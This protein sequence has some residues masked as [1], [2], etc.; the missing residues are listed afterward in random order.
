MKLPRILLLAACIMAAI[1]LN[2]NTIKASDITDS[3]GIGS[4]SE[5]SVLAGSTVTNTGATVL[6]RSLGLYPG[7][8]VTGF[9]PGLVSAPG[10]FEVATAAAGQAQADLTG[11]YMD[12]A[13]RALTGTIPAD[14]AGQTLGSGVYAAS[15]RGPLSLGGTVVLDA[16]GN[17][18]AVFIFQTDSSLT[19]AS[20]SVVSLI[21][22]AQACRVHWVVGSSATLG[23]GSTFV[24][25][26]MAQESITV[27][28]GATVRGRVLARSG[29]VTL[30]SNVFTPASCQPP[31][32][33]PPSTEGPP[34]TVGTPPVSVPST[35]KPPSGPPPGRLPD[36]GSDLRPVLWLATFLVAAGLTVRRRIRV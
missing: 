34:T 6:P 10:V 21:G 25:T 17:T 5:Y 28:T 15:D 8:S 35:P 18:D 27:T 32:D 36:T 13:G 30:D 26:I 33:T 29:A 14:L 3:P 2:V 22:G 1:G 24:G 19:T 16:G 9:P 31:Q 23:T 11:G 12:A 4:A 7:T 20:S